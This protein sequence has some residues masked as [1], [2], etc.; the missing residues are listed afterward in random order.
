MVRLE[1]LAIFKNIHIET[2]IWASLFSSSMGPIQ[3]QTLSMLIVF[4]LSKINLACF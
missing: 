4:E 1:I 2:I 3:Q